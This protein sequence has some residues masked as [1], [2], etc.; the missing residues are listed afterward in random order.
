MRFLVLDLFSFVF[1][2]AKKRSYNEM[3]DSS[4]TETSKSNN[5]G[6]RTPKK[7]N[8]DDGDKTPTNSGD[9]TPTN[10]SGEVTPNVT[11]IEDLQKTLRNVNKALKGE[12][13]S[14][15]DM[16]EIKEEYSSYFDEYSENTTTTEGLEQ[17][18]EYLEG[19]LF[20]SLGKGKLDDLNNALNE[21]KKNDSKNEASTSETST[22][23]AST[24]ET[25][26]SETS[27]SSVKQSDGLSP[28]D[29]VLEKQSMDPLDPTDDLD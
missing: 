14:K 11:D 22:G 29:F 2:A 13:V 28:V 17:V 8:S 5:D 3:E 15:E 25:S 4:E 9:T 19:E 24:S 18:K 7:N 23:K 12:K 1:F 16:A 10:N 20:P 21:I 27:T 26:T 6:D